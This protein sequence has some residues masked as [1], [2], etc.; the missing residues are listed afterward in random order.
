MFIQIF[1]TSETNC[2][3][4]VLFG[5]KS[6]NI[7]SMS[8]EEFRSLGTAESTVMAFLPK[9]QALQGIVR[10]SLVFYCKELE[11]CLH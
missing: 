8:S 3:Y 6:N 7:L 5:T 9:L 10:K 11:S 1:T 2:L 4:L